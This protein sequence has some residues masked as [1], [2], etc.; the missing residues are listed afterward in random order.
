MVNKIVSVK[1]K[2]DCCGHSFKIQDLSALQIE[3]KEFDGVACPLCRFDL[4]GYMDFDCL[5]SL[6][7]SYL[8]YKVQEQTGNKDLTI[9]DL[10]EWFEENELV[11]FPNFKEYFYWKHS[12]SSKEYLIYLLWNKMDDSGDYIKIGE[13]EDVPVAFIY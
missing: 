9:E 4:L 3:S 1:G 10:N 11:L 5:S 6:Q 12:D 8:L 2:C 7:K 13:Q